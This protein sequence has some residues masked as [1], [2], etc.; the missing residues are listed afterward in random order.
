MVSRA[1][2][3]DKHREDAYDLHGVGNQRLESLELLE[4]IL[5]L[6]IVGRGDNHA[7]HEG[8]EGGDTIALT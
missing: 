7:G 4:V 8:T 6:D 3:H 2:S 1:P 5:G